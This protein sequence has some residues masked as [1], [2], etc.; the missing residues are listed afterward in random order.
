VSRIYLG[1]DCATPY[2]SLAL[3]DDS[4]GPLAAFA[5]E[6][7]RDHAARIVSELVR[8]FDRAGLAPG[9]V[10]GI[11]VGVGPGSYTG[12]RVALATAKGLG[13]AWGVPLGGVSTLA[14][15]AANGLL[16]G[17][18]GAAALDARHGNVYAAV[19]RR[20]DDR[21][22]LR[23]EEVR[24]VAKL[25]RAGLAE[26]LGGVRVIEGVAPSAVH[27]AAAARAGDPAEAVY[28]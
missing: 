8:L 24:A 15:I 2:L 1:I 3:F 23:L 7:G 26:R 4:R 25:P 9:D 19:Y 27:T 6:V 20:P 11:G 18:L 5:E 22:E 13:R 17:E 21:T 14:A 28:L 16:P 10:A 12:V